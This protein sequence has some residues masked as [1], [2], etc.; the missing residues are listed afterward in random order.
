METLEKKRMTSEDLESIYASLRR[1]LPVEVYAQ[2]R[3]GDFSVLDWHCVDG[4]SALDS[5]YGVRR[6]GG[7]MRFLVNM[8][9]ALIEHKPDFCLD[10]LDVLFDV[11]SKRFGD[12]LTYH[13]DEAEVDTCKGCGYL[14]HALYKS[15]EEYGLTREA[16]DK[17]ASFLPR[18]GKVILE[19]DHT[20]HKEVGIIEVDSYSLVA[21]EGEQVF[22]WHSRYD[23][24]VVFYL[25]ADLASRLDNIEPHVL[26][27][28]A[29]N[30]RNLNKDVTVRKLNA[31]LLPQYKAT[32]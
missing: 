14:N 19:G 17:L 28:A 27:Q 25:A 12:K 20:N 30:R 23:N 29:I 18:I 10:D 11:V 1:E 2:V 4:R 15:S 3:K 26:H 13:T 31:H 22:V 32:H 9:G 6:F 7:S 21:K 24:I 8:T 5:G 16:A